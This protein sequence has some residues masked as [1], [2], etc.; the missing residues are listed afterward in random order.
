MI[1][2][3]LAISLFIA[4]RLDQKTEAE[5]LKKEPEFHPDFKSKM[6]NLSGATYQKKNNSIQKALA[7]QNKVKKQ[8]KAACQK[9]V[10]S[11]TPWLESLSQEE[12]DKLG[13]GIIESIAKV[14]N[15]SLV[16]LPT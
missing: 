11:L 5:T 7:E 4:A 16:Q 14:R 6:R 3:L 9:E 2:F 8:I 13:Q 15:L 12:K 1:L 10:N